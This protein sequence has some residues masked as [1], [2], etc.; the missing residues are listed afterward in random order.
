M[1]RDHSSSILF[2]MHVERCIRHKCRKS[3][4]TSVYTEVKGLRTRSSEFPRRHVRRGNFLGPNVRGPRVGLSKSPG[5]LLSVVVE[6]LDA[7]DDHGFGAH[8]NDIS[9]A[10]ISE[11][12]QRTFR[13]RS[14]YVY[15]FSLGPRDLYQ[16]WS[17]GIP[18]DGGANVASASPVL[19]DATGVQFYSLLH[20]RDG[21]Q[22]GLG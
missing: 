10:N 6:P 3:Q 11:T 4:E 22:A 13:T 2:H 5:R 8:G 1:G 16:K 7:H 19:P 15:L 20:R 17:L 14:I 9:A 12:I 18:G 21:G